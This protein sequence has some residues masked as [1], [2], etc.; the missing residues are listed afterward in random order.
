MHRYREVHI[1][2]YL[3]YLQIQYIHNGW[4][5]SAWSQIPS[6]NI[7]VQVLA[8]YVRSVEFSW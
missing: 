8:L 7:F 1:G 5:V 4:Y 2:K 3:Q 6:S